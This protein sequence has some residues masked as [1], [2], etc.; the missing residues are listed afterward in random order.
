MVNFRSQCRNYFVLLALMLLLPAMGAF[1]TTYSSVFNVEVVDA[2]NNPVN[3]AKV[4]LWDVNN[5]YN[6]VNGVT[7]DANPTDEPTGFARLTMPAVTETADSTSNPSPNIGV[8]VLPPAGSTFT[9]KTSKVLFYN[10]FTEG[11]IA[12]AVK[13]QLEEGAQVRITPKHENDA[14]TTNALAD[15]WA[16]SMTVRVPGVPENVFTWGFTEITAAMGTNTYWDVYWPADKPGFGYFHNDSNEWN[17]TTPVYFDFQNFSFNAGTAGMLTEVELVQM[18][19]MKGAFKVVEDL[20]GT[21]IDS[22]AWRDLHYGMYDTVNNFQPDQ[23]YWFPVGTYNFN[24]ALNNHIVG[25]GFGAAKGIWNNVEITVE[26]TATTP[27][28]RT[29]VV[30]GGTGLTVKIILGD[31]L[32]DGVSDA[33][34]YTRVDV[35]KLVDFG[36]YQ[37]WVGYESTPGYVTI[38]TDGAD[39]SGMLYHRLNAGRYRIRL[40]DNNWNPGVV[41]SARNCFAYVTSDEFEVPDNSLQVLDKTLHMPKKPAFKATVDANF[42]NGFDFSSNNPIRVGYLPEEG[43]EYGYDITNNLYDSYDANGLIIDDTDPTIKHIFIPFVQPG[44]IVVMANLGDPNNVMAPLFK[45]FE[46]FAID[47]AAG[48]QGPANPYMI[49][50]TN[51]VAYT[52]TVKMQGVDTLYQGKATINVAPV[53]TSST[54]PILNIPANRVFTTTYSP[55]HLEW[56]NTETSFE[57]AVEVNQPYLVTADS[58]NYGELPLQSFVPYET[59]VDTDVALAQDIILEQGGMFNGQIQV[60]GQNQ[61]AEVRIAVSRI[62]DAN[63]F[64]QTWEPP[65][66]G[67]TNPDGSFTVS[68]LE[69]GRYNVRINIDGPDLS[70]YYNVNY[71]QQT[72]PIFNHEVFVDAFSTITEPIKFNFDPAQIGFASGRITDELGNPIAGIKVAFT[73]KEEAAAMDF[74][75]PHYQGNYFDSAKAVFFCIT[76]ENGELTQPGN[77]PGMI[78]LPAGEYDMWANGILVQPTGFTYDM[79]YFYMY[80]DVANY[81][82]KK[83]NSVT[84]YAG[85]VSPMN[86][87]IIERRY[88][89]SGVITESGNPVDYLSFSV[90]DQMGQYAG[91]GYTDGT[92]KYTIESLKPGMVKFG[93]MLDGEAGKRFYLAPVNFDPSVATTLNV[94]LDPASLAQVTINTVDGSDSPLP[95]AG[96]SIVM[97]TDPTLPQFS[98]FYLTWA[99]SGENGVID[100]RLPDISAMPELTGFNYRFEPAPYYHE[101]DGQ[102]TQLYAPEPMILIPGQVEPH[103]AKWVNGATLE[104][105][106]TNPTMVAADRTIGL[107]ILNDNFYQPMSGEMPTDGMTPTTPDMMN[108]PS[109]DEFA[110]NPF[111]FLSDSSRLAFLEN[112]KFTFEDLQP[113]SAYTFLSYELSRPLSFEE[114]NKIGD[115]DDKDGKL[116][117]PNVVLFFRN[118]VGPVFMDTNLETVNTTFSPLANLTVDSSP[119]PLTIET[120]KDVRIGFSE[121]RTM[122]SGMFTWPA[123]FVASESANAAFP[124]KLPASTTYQI[125]YTPKNGDPF[126]PK[127]DENVFLPST[128]KTHVMNLKKVNKLNGAVTRNGLP[129]NGMLI[130]VTEGANVFAPD[131]QPIQIPINNGFYSSGLSS[132]YYFGYVV[133][134]MGAPMYINLQMGDAD[135][136]K[137]FTLIAG[138]KITGRVVEK[139]DDT[140]FMPVPG[141]AVNVMRKRA[142]NSE[143]ADGAPFYPYPAMF[144]RSEVYCAPDGSFSFMAE[145]NVNYYLQGMSPMG[146]RPGLPKPVVVAAIDVTDVTIELKPGLS[147]NGTLAGPAIIEARPSFQD[148]LQSQIAEQEM[149]ST[150]AFWQDDMGKYP[151]NIEGLDPNKPYDLTIMP[152]P[153]PDGTTL[154]IK[155]ITNVIPGSF[156]GHI[157]FAQGF[158]LYGQLVDEAGN[159]LKAAGVPVNLAMTLGMDM[160]APP[161]GYT[162]PDGWTDPTMPPPDPTLPPPDPTL[163]PPDPT[164]PPP[165]SPSV[166]VAPS[167]R[168]GVRANI[169]DPTALPEMP[170][171]NNFVQE[172][173]WTMTDANGKFVFEG[174]PGFANAF[175]KTEQGFTA[176]GIDYGRGRTESFVSPFTIDVKEYER[177]IKIPVGGK[178]IGRLIDEL[179]Q[180]I[181]IG[182]VEAFT[183]DSWAEAKPDAE[184]KFVLSGLVP[185]PAYMVNVRE[186]PGR[187]QLF[188]A[189]ISVEPGRITDLG[190]LPINKAIRIKGLLKNVVKALQYFFFY[191]TT[192]DS[193][194]SVIAFDGSKTVSDLQL[195]NR[196]YMQDIIGENMMTWDPTNTEATDVP[197]EMFAKPGKANL[198]MVVHNEDETGVQT[199]V[200]WGWQPGLTLPTQEQLTADG[201][202]AFDMSVNP[203]LNETAF[204]FIAGTLKHAVNVDETYFPTDA[205]IALYPVRKIGET[206]EYELVNVPF[207][208]AVT[209]PVDGMWMVEGIPQ[210]TYR[211]KVISRKYGTQ[212][213]KKVI[214]VGIEPVFEEILLGAS[215]VEISGIIEDANQNKLANASVNMILRNLSTSTDANGKFSFYLP[216]NEFVIPQLEIKKAGYA[217]LRALDVPANAAWTNGFIATEAKNLGTYQLA[218]AAGVAEV[219]VTDKISNA[220]II[221]AE[222]TM[223]VEKA[224]SIDGSSFSIFTP[225]DV[226]YADDSGKA[227]FSS[228]PVGEKVRFRA[229]YF[230]YVATTTEV[231]T[232]GADQVGIALSK[233][234]PKVFYT[235][236]V[237]PVDGDATQLQLKA[238]FDFNQVVERAKI[239]FNFNGTDQD[240]AGTKFTYPDILGGR[241][242]NFAF[243]DTFAKPTVDG[244]A[245]NAIVAYD[246]STIGTFDVMAGLKFRKEYEV[247]PMAA[248]GFAGRMTDASGNQLPTGLSV[249]PGYLPPEVDSFELKVE[250]KPTTPAALI[251]STEPATFAGPTFEF[252]FNGGNFGAGTEQQNGLFEVT[253]AYEEGTKLEPRWQDKD[254]NWSKV[255]II[256][257]SLKWDSPSAG[258][259]TFKVSHLTKFAVLANVDGALSGVR[260]DY[261]GDGTVD[262]ND[263][264]YQIAWVQS[265]NSNISQTVQNRA[266]EIYSAVKLPTSGSLILP[267]DTVDDLTGEGKND[268][269]DLVLFISWIQAGGT[270]DTNVINAR[271]KEI[272]TSVVGA[273]SNLPGEKVNR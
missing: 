49:S 169:V 211:I 158:K 233:A 131:Y 254:G 40:F 102:Q 239:G 195:L 264:I 56:D 27:E 269:N 243:A 248:N 216:V 52:G 70:D 253:L 83:V 79:G 181:K 126:L 261:N 267:S 214:T 28:T 85:Q 75:E 150:P 89:L 202:E 178:I 104:V 266:V 191:G 108:M 5:S 127:V 203:L 268:L 45:V 147:V 37:H 258:Y 63:D 22:G 273:I 77:N 110:K 103:V 117:G 34:A 111:G 218:A 232:T 206:T 21:T 42:A 57:F 122:T 26:D 185:A 80:N 11:A 128:G 133:P 51:F 199:L 200:T 78:P 36:G 12:P 271:A 10:F 69:S 3:G 235:G 20:G 237:I 208:T 241:L 97:S 182:L 229:K 245:V 46:P 240:V 61:A 160:F 132:G 265:G 175:L 262:L 62:F 120:A 246:L 135:L 55:V 194:L 137:D 138:V 244:T 177:N 32:G 4:Y 30:N 210:G 99:D 129:V 198:G 164:Q 193:G 184:G 213:F 250:D 212:F 41:D 124:V 65:R 201:K 152:S 39:A 224:T 15:G 220:P 252:T 105:V 109:M 115:V 166:R 43:S 163:P 238:N 64:N 33:L 44:R 82:G 161:E 257:D 1:A 2:G 270:T 112:G 121:D 148:A 231:L 118:F 227:K 19:K 196:S 176:N 73:P 156:L 188:R 140:N 81:E 260:C 48:T 225:A 74:Y 16:T 143:L 60:S 29:F 151:F 6:G 215:V 18:P 87:S 67:L 259:V 205:V 146:Y 50:D 207:P 47:P 113:H 107:L 66:V 249:P 13:I 174:V 134:A 59:I 144:G 219:T 230:Y 88:S 256:E 272:Y 251:G 171:L 189:N 234:P 76:N 8:L 183:G 95:W 228:V 190:A 209:N 217:T 168:M 101:E 167:L 84:V 187:A 25:T 180:P 186:V 236:Q 14:D 72:M 172:G 139:I 96:G 197:F 92:G 125:K 23:I 71:N 7:G 192:E 155:K 247:D 98:Y 141:A 114:I 54:D 130:L 223:I 100:I 86:D 136:T 24:Y 153:L 53:I 255:G 242:T 145:P 38:P 90:V 179:G 93:M 9:F 31:T 116:N 149:I 154:A 226:Q 170:N 221:G 173:L 91:W 94:N 68:G 123:V 165:T 204:G 35:E 222:V 58:P 263:L 119:D 142:A 159:P 157:E 106:V 17:F 162:P